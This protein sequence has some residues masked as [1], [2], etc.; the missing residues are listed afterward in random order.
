MVTE[1]TVKYAVAMGGTLKP[2][3]VEAT[4]KSLQQRGYK[5]KKD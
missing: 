4:M 1:D 3:I 2:Q 5:T